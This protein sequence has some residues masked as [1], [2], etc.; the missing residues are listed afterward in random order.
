MTQP[1]GAGQ[2]RGRL[3]AR[4]LVRWDEMAAGL[5]LAIVFVAV[6]W[7]VF[8]RYVSPRPSPW[9]HE[10]S[11]IG[12]AWVVFLGAAAAARKG[13]HIGVDLFTARLPAH[14]RALLARLVALAMAAGIAYV[15]W[16]A[17][18]I[19]VSAWT[20]PTPLMRLPFTVVYASAAVGLA[21][22]AVQSL[23]EAIRGRGP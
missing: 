17:T 12:F 15:A 11:N 23:I 2:P 21:A 10:L 7:G 19:S 5:A 13:L 6:A 1:E 22:M 3:P 18:S 14:P 8:A 4:W 16:L 20:R 9:A